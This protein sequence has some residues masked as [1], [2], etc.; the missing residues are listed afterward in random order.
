MHQ[1]PPYNVGP[2]QAWRLGRT[3]EMPLSSQPPRPPKFTGT[4]ISASAFC[5]EVARLWPTYVGPGHI[6][7]LLDGEAR[8][9]FFQQLRSSF[10]TWHTFAGALITAPQTTWR[11]N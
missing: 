10:A 9:W 3:L 2:L 5:N 11:T 8:D 6:L 7:H 1:V 4:N